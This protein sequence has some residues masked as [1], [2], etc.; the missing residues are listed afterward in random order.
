MGKKVTLQRL[1][2]W[3]EIILEIWWFNTPIEWRIPYNS[4][5]AKEMLWKEEWDSI[6]INLWAWEI[7][8]EIIEIS[9]IVNNL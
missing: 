1:D 5:I 3:E 9:R 2:N 7:E 8:V 6:E 4:Q